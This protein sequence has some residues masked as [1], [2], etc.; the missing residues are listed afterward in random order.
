[1]PEIFLDNPYMLIEELLWTNTKMIFYFF[2]K[3]VSYKLYLLEVVIRVVIIEVSFF[4]H[5]K[6]KL[7]GL[8]F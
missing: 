2:I 8:M 5:R 6:T 4:R 3:L 7:F 1:M